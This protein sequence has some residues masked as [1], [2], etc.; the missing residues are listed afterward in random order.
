MKTYKPLKMNKLNQG[1][2]MPDLKYKKGKTEPKYTKAHSSPKRVSY[3]FLPMLKSTM[4]VKMPQIALAKRAANSFVPKICMAED[5][6]QKNSGGFSQKGLKSTYTRRYSLSKTISRLIS[7]KL[8]SSQSNKCTP[9]KN[10][11]KKT[12]PTSPM[13]RLYLSG[14]GILRRPFFIFSC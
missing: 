4:T 2:M 9:P 11:M 1:S 14:F 6:S 3:N 8:I 7:A 10:G 5:W 12:A 13:S